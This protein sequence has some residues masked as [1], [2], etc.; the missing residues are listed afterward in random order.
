MIFTLRI[1]DKV[2][3]V[4][5]TALDY[6]SFQSV[7]SFLNKYKKPIKNKIKTLLQENPLLNETDLYETDDPVTKRIP[8]QNSKISH[9]LHTLLAGIP[10]Q[11]FND[12]HLSQDILSIFTNSSSSVNKSNNTN[13]LTQTPIKPT[14]TQPLPSL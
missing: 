5:Y 10:H 14:T 13:A 2:N 6:F 12:V 1:Q 11:N 3:T 8:Q 7:S 4:T 9:E